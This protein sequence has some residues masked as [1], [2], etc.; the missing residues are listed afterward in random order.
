M[1]LSPLDIS[2]HEFSKTMRGYDPAEV[3]AFLERVAE[4]LADLQKE[5][6]TL[7]EQA[8]I[9][10]A[11]IKAFRELEQGMR[12]AMVSSQDSLRQS[13]EQIEKERQNVLREANLKAEEIKL[14]TEQDVRKIREEFRE[15]QIHRDAYVKRLRFLLKSQTDLLELIEKESPDLPD[16]ES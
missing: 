8:H 1:S 4:E 12:D 13:Q 6:A 11:Q 5:C 15:L 14:R 9:N 3:R 2:K 16:D 10:A 7:T